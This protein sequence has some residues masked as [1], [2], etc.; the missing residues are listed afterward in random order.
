LNPY[1]IRWNLDIQRS[2]GKGMV[3]EFGYTGNHA[4][5]LPID[6][7]L[8][9]IPAQ[10]LSTDPVRT[11]EQNDINTRN[12]A[13]VANPFAGLLPGTN[14]NGATVNF[15]QLVVAFPQFPV[16]TSPTTNGNNVTMSA[17]NASSSYFHAAQVRFEKRFSAGFQILAN[18]QF[19]RTIA[20]DNYLNSTFG[21]LEK[22]P[23]D[24]DRP[25]R[26]VTS[27]S[28]ELPIGRGKR[29]LGSPSGFAGAVLDRIVG[30]W[31]I[32]GIYSFES[33]GPA[34]TWGDVVYVGG[35][36][37]WQASN[38]DHT[39]DTTRFIRDTNLQPVSH[40]RTF[41]SR[42]A[43]LRLP[44]TN[45]VDSSI[46][47]NTRIRERVMLQYRAEFFN[48]FNH[49]VFNAPQLSPTNSAFGTIS[50]VYNLE[51]HIQMALRLSW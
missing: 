12:S 30:G 35:D 45:N 9:G 31:V 32:N 24:I 47:K 22:R 44:P 16:A 37:N 25:H 48:T 27:F 15:S 18:Y 5:H 39:F 29:L 43:D 20:R 13:P 4:V 36:L 38:V 42:F 14:L 33:G 8:N 40:I 10:Y 11:K 7:Q 21:P 49:P 2:I 50:G 28:Y 41:P 23:A 34:S 26:F 3:L 46:I 19:G 17:A 1:S 6:Q 51:R